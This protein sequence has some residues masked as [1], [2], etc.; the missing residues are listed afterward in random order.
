VIDA[1]V[2]RGERR[3]IE[4]SQPLLRLVKERICATLRVGV[5]DC[6][7]RGER[8]RRQT[9]ITLDF[10]PGVSSGGD[11]DPRELL[12]RRRLICRVIDEQPHSVARLL[13]DRVRHTTVIAVFVDEALAV[14]VDENALHEG[15]GRI[16]G[17]R[18]EPL[19]HIDG[20]AAHA[21]SHPNA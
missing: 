3:L 12:K 8:A 7:R 1:T 4:R 10:F 14:R 15:A 6:D 11:L 16:P 19:M 13:K 21:H 9:Q 5:V 20:G 18:D 17:D 2:E